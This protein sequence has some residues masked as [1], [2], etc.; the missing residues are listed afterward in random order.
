MNTPD[1]VPGQ[2]IQSQDHRLHTEPGTT[3]E[4][5]NSLVTSDKCL[6]MPFNSLASPRK[7]F[8]RSLGLS[9]SCF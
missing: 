3:S 9:K 4:I 5:C 1:S 7:T 2:R 6:L 8:L